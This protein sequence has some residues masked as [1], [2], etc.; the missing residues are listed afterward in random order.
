MAIIPGIPGVNVTISVGD[1]TATEYDA[2][3]D[4]DHG[5]LTIDDF[6]DTRSA[7]AALPS[8][9]GDRSKREVKQQ[10]ADGAALPYVL[11]Y[12]EAK[13]GE[14]FA[15]KIRQDTTFRH[16][17]HHF[18]Y[19]AKVDGMNIRIQHEGAATARARGEPWESIVDSIL[20]KDPV[21]VSGWVE[22]RF[23]FGALE[24]TE[25]PMDPT[26]DI[27][28][29]IEKA[30]SVGVI[31][32][33]FY[34]LEDST[35][36]RDSVGAP[37]QGWAKKVSEKTLKGR[38][39]DCA[40]DLSQTK[41]TRAPR[42]YTVAKFT[43]RKQRPFAIFEFRYRSMDG[44]IK[45][46]VL[47]RPGDDDDDDL[48]FVSSRPQVVKNE[49]NAPIVIDGDD[50]IVEANAP[51]RVKRER[52]VKQERGLKRERQ[53]QDEGF[54]ARSKSRRLGDGR[55]EIDLTDD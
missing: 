45:E 6:H 20:V 43:D 15:I 25:E 23:R 11:K 3:D 44:L 47:R 53:D 28:K 17:S 19:V 8:G 27:K 49:S 30:K 48:K 4:D 18:G 13:A 51:Q 33:S 32:L 54:R 9:D 46:G 31:R 1:Q 34:H 50:D 55:V 52:G 5:G 26:E 41:P 36:V 35:E 29:Q 14:Q 24:V 42:P 10:A 7:M 21:S 22:Q 37:V 39:V 16:Y 2:P 12:V 40:L 38:A